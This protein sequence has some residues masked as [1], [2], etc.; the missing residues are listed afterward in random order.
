MLLFVGAK[1]QP[2]IGGLEKK[3]SLDFLSEDCLI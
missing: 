1:V 3:H 2:G